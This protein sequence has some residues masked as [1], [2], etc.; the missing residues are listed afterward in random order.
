MM[1][2]FERVL[3]NRDDMSAAEAKEALESARAEVSDILDNG[4]SYCEI[5]Q[6]LLDEYG[7]EMDYIFDLI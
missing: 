6:L 5:E 7:L 1:T 4:G 2:E 3:I